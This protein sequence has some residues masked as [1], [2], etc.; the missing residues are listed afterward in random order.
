MKEALKEAEK[1]YQE[2]EVPVGAVIVKEDQIIARA[3]NKKEQE[4]DVTAHAEILAIR[5]ASKVLD[6]WR[7][8][9]CEI[10]I[11]A[12]PCTMCLG[13]ILQSKIKKIVYG[14]HENEFGS[15]E[16]NRSFLDLNQAKNLE[17][18]PG[19]L[20]DQSRELLER[21]FDEKRS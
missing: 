15:I 17:I 9:D 12:E 5:E 8:T 20:E 16:M 4:Q 13:A 3:H 6:N 10:Y 1:A 7:L 21:F 11:T 2:G 18:Y 19:I 14:T